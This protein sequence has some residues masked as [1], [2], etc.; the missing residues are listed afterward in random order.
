MV[1]TLAGKRQIVA[2]QQ[3]AVAG[4]EI[5]TG[6]E[7][8]SFPI[9]NPQSNCASPLVV[10]DTVITSSGYGYGTHRIEIKKD[11]TGFKAA[12]LW[13]SLKLKAKF[14]DMIV[15]DGFLYGLND[16]R[17]TDRKSVV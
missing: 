2:I 7:L 11:E 10:G 6:K 4:F 3:K 9:G 17:M 15:K 12:E 14:A 1:A 5:E 16:G 13:H 8:W